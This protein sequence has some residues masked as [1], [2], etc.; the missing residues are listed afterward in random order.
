MASLPQLNNNAAQSSVRV[1]LPLLSES[2]V[3]SAPPTSRTTPSSPPLFQSQPDS[4]PATPRLTTQSRYNSPTLE[5]DHDSEDDDDADAPADVISETCKLWARYN[6]ASERF[7]FTR[8]M[9]SSLGLNHRNR[10]RFGAL[11]RSAK[12]LPVL[13]SRCISTGKRRA[14]S[15]PYA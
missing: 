6:S 10:Q 8:F 5:S 3:L 12:H 14:L 4:D 9:H 2:S 1:T 11:P 15:I 13:G 7:T